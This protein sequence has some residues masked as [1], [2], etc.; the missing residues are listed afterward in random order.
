MPASAD[1]G[2]VAPFSRAASPSRG[3]PG[4]RPVSQSEKTARSED[5]DP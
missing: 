3:P 1:V 5:G 4:E 2:H